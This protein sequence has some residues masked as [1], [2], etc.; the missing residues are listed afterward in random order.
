LAFYA[1]AT[2][3]VELNC[4]CN[5]KRATNSNLYFGLGLTTQLIPLYTQTTIHQ[6]G[7]TVCHAINSLVILHS[8]L[9][10]RSLLQCQSIMMARRSQIVKAAPPGLSSETTKQEGSVLLVCARKVLEMLSSVM[11]NCRNPTFFWVTA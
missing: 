5:C 1:G 7:I 8:F 10:Y 3:I 2:D 9:Q 4:I 11:K 6:N